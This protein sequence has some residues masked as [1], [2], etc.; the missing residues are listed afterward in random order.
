METK[1]A[2]PSHELVLERTLKAPRG[3]VWRCWT[4]PVLMPLWYCPKPWYVSDVSLDLRAGGVCSMTMNG[5]SGETFPNLGIYLEVVPGERLVF[6][7]A[8]TSAWMPS[9]KA[10]MVGVISMQDAPGGG[11]HYKAVARHWNA[12]DREEH[13]KMGFHEG[14]AIAA[15]QLEALAASL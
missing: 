5:P 4:E 15:D 13:I 7:D 3:T 11:T 9:G 1:V 8:F 12:A 6:T 10:F 14:W 2:M